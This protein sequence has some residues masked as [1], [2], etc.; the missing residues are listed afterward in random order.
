MSRTALSPG[1]PT[2]SFRQGSAPLHVWVMGLHYLPMY[3]T[4]AESFRLNWLIKSS[5]GRVRVETQLQKPTV[6]IHGWS[7]TEIWALLYQARCLIYSLP[8]PKRTI[9]NPCMPLQAAWIVI[10]GP[11]CD[12]VSLDFAWTEANPCKRVRNQNQN[13]P[14]KLFPRKE[15]HHRRCFTTTD[16]VPLLGK[17]LEVAA[18]WN[19]YFLYEEVEQ[20]FFPNCVCNFSAPLFLWFLW[21]EWGRTRAFLFLLTPW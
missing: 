14:F 13:C 9:R 7:L 12:V 17:A 18:T 11:M 20:A 4:W 3:S 2:S 16:C 19:F 15:N 10:F 21:G 6:S 1:L 5:L 8:I